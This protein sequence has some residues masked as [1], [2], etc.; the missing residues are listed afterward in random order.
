M[1]WFL[2]F[3]FL[4]VESSAFFSFNFKDPENADKNVER[5]EEEIREYIDLKFSDF[6]EDD[7]CETCHSSVAVPVQKIFACIFEKPKLVKLVKEEIVFN[8]M[9]DFKNISAE[10]RQKNCNRHLGAY[11][12]VLECIKKVDAPEHQGVIRSCYKM[13][14][15]G[16]GMNCGKMDKKKIM[17][18][19]KNGEKMLSDFPKYQNYIKQAEFLQKTQHE[20][21]E[22]YHCLPVR[23]GEAYQIAA[24]E[25]HEIPFYAHEY[26]ATAMHLI[27]TMK[28][29]YPFKSFEEC[30]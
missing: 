2:L 10:E 22:K 13:V 3:L 16:R 4:I 27:T 7:I 12:G 17:E 26:I 6:N 5:Y 25:T 19:F 18:V 24:I 15:Y 29:N 30:A 14:K 28:G 9:N 20:P 23:V 21:S 1:K 8:A 11:G